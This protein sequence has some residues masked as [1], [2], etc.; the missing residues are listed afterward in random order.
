MYTGVIGC[1]PTVAAPGQPR[2]RSR[3]VWRNWPDSSL[4]TSPSPQPQA[5][6]SAA[7]SGPAWW[8][9]WS[10][11]GCWFVV[12]ESVENETGEAGG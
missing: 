7:P 3:R 6:H 2:G 5:P 4:T 10:I 12:G 9:P 8:R 1:G 11:M